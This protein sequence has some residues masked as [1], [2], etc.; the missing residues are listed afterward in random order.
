MTEKKPKAL[1]APANE[2]APINLFIATAARALAEGTANEH[3]QTQFVK[4][5]VFQACGKNYPPYHATDR[6]TAF[7]LGRHFVADQ[8]NGL[9]TVDLSVLRRMTNE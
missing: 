6:D 2:P 5:L 9:L 7:A 8:F 4:W 1:R 3:Q